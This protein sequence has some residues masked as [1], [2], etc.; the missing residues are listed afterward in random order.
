MN[1]AWERA[2]FSGDYQGR[3]EVVRRIVGVVS[4]RLEHQ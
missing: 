3:E 2:R 4:L 1:G